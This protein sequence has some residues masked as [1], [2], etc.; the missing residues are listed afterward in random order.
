MWH[1]SNRN[2]DEVQNGYQPKMTN[3]WLKNIESWVILFQ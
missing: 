1:M 2:S 3:E